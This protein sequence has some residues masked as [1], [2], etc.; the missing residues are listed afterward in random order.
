MSKWNLHVKAT[1]ATMKKKGTFKKGDNLTK[2][3]KE[4][5]KTYHKG[6]SSKASRK[7]RRRSS[8]RGLFFG[9]GSGGPGAT[10]AGPVG[11]Q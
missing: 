7:T 3:L 8:K 11:G 6:S 5:S 2:V 9:G 4:A 1:M 10:T